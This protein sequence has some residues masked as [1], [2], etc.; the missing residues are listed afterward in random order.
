MTAK[1]PSDKIDL[2]PH[3]F[4][5]P[6][7]DPNYYKDKFGAEGAPA[8]YHCFRR[9]RASSILN[10]L[11]AVV[12]DFPN[13]VYIVL[14]ATH[15]NLVRDHGEISA[16]PRRLGKRNGV[17]RNVIFFNRFVDNDELLEFLGATDISRRI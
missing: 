7:A 16:Q 11:P 8:A 17:E 13:V 1:A 9:T 12:R 3:G 10:A 4:L 5:T 2:I 14:G 6:F 15:P